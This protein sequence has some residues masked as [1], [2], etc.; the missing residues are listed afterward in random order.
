MKN[1][2][3][4]FRKKCLVCNGHGNIKREY[5]MMIMMPEGMPF[6]DYETCWQCYGSGREERIDYTIRK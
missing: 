1:C 6:V 4:Q 2:Y 3:I 5:H